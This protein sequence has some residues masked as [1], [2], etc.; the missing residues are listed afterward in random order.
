MVLPAA[1]TASDGLDGL[2][3]VQQRLEVKATSATAGFNSPGTLR[4]TR[5][6]NVASRISRSVR[7]NREWAIRS[8]SSG[9]PEVCERGRQSAPD[10]GLLWRPARENHVAFA[11]G[12]GKTTVLRPC[13]PRQST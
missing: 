4:A 3:S 2:L 10:R 13:F 5:E 8:C 7:R 12:A 6:A 11:A 9:R 1:L